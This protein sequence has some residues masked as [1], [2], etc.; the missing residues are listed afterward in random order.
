M[1]QKRASILLNSDLEGLARF[2]SYKL[3]KNKK[4]EAEKG[5]LG[6]VESQNSSAM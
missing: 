1:A 4:K 3:Q 5:G 2:K 6:T